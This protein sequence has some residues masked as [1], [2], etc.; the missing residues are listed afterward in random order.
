MVSLR[1]FGVAVGLITPIIFEYVCTVVTRRGLW[2]NELRVTG[3]YRVPSEIM[4]FV[5]CPLD[6]CL[7]VLSAICDDVRDRRGFW[8]LQFDKMGW[9]YLNVV[10]LTRKPAFVTTSGKKIKKGT[11]LF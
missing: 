8:K 7:G 3:F 5:F 10:R 4:D 2:I 6:E 1:I 11:L 9:G